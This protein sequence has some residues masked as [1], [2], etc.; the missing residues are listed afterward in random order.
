MCLVSALE[1]FVIQSWDKARSLG[2]LNVDMLCVD[3]VMDKC[4]DIENGK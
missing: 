3:T 2:F 4:Y 1:N